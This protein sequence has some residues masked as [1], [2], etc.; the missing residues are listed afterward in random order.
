MKRF[1]VTCQL[2]NGDHVMKAV[3]SEDFHS[4]SA[5]GLDHAFAQGGRLISVTEV[6]YRSQAWEREQVDPLLHPNETIAALW[7]SDSMIYG[8]VNHEDGHR[9]FRSQI[10]GEERTMTRH[11]LV[12]SLSE[13]I[14]S[15][16]DLMDADYAA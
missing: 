11:G 13:A 14:R 16:V 3:I 12:V 6:H 15:A 8:V 4:A 10:E 1:Q 7:W 2:P 5:E 9:A